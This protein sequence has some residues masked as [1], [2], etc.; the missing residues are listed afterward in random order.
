MAFMAFANI[1]ASV[2]CSKVMLVAPRSVKTFGDLGEWC[3]G[4]TGRWLV[5]ISQMAVCFMVACAFLVLGG[6]LLDGLFPAAFTGKTWIVIMAASCVPICL[7]PTMKE[8][9]GVA[10]TGCLCTLLADFIALGVLL[11]GMR[12]HPSVPAPEITFEQVAT[13][14]GNLSLSYGAGIVIPALQ[15]QHS[16]PA[17]MPRVIF[18]TLG[19]I[20]AL[21]LVLAVMGYS[22][23]GCQISGNLLFTIYA[24]STTGLTN[25]GFRSDWGA[26]VLAYLFMQL[27][28]QIAFAVIL[29][30]VFYLFERVFL[31]MHSRHLDTDDVDY[32]TAL[33]PQEKSIPAD[34]NKPSLVSLEADVQDTTEEEDEAAEYAGRAMRYIPLRLVV[35]SAL[36]II[37]ILLKDQFLDLADFV[38]ASAISISCI[39]LPI[40]FYF[41]KLWTTIPMWEKAAGSL[42]MVVCLVLSIYVSYKTGKNLFSPPTTQGPPFPFCAGELKTKLFYN[43]TEA[44]LIK[45]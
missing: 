36:T 20:S 4:R 12:G 24:N 15:R 28:I 2:V 21:F 40:I 32:A 26:V 11:H 6:I 39:L 23:V 18:V 19:V 34:E 16:E 22:A 7:T 33:T 35:I 14:F 29:H 5:L 13:T 43:A 1:Y 45:S 41:K 9:A 31:G 3:M 27:H 42:V 44:S 30:P 38:G 37:S 8:G 10:F 17:R 25:L